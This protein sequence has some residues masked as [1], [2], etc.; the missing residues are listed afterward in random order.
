MRTSSR[1]TESLPAF[2]ILFAGAIWGL[3]WLPMRAFESA[4]LPGD[5]LTLL[6]FAIPAL[7]LLPLVI[8]RKRVPSHMLITV[9]ATGIFTG[10][11]S[12]LYAV[13][14]VLTTVAKAL[15]LFY[16]TP[17]W[18]TLFGYLILREKLRFA[19]VVALFLGILGLVVILDTGPLPIPNNTGDW[20]A[21]S[22]GIAWGYGTVRLHSQQN[23][24][25]CESLFA[26]FAGGVTVIAFVILLPLSDFAPFPDLHQVMRFIPWIAL[27][28]IG[29]IL[30][31]IFLVYWGA[32]RLSPARV[33]LLLMS[34]VVVGIVSA[35]LLTD[36]PFGSREMIG[37]VLIIGAAL[38]EIFKQESID[39]R[40][41]G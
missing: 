4:Q 41:K 29:I 11:G 15:L 18:S 8:Y 12:V 7:T 33:G 17:V 22:S 9:L 26:Y 30:V 3:F 1:L 16:L 2:A 24:P 34:E 25:I 40:V 20:I 31:S 21:L 6:F 23:V 38:V 10:A 5:W 39:I 27:V 35:A 37:S 32:L 36:E 14:L 28:A 13:S 19:R